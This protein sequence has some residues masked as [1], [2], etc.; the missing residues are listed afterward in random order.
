MGFNTKYHRAEWGKLLTY[1]KLFPT[2]KGVS[3]GILFVLGPGTET[4][5]RGFVS[6]CHITGHIFLQNKHLTKQSQVTLSLKECCILCFPCYVLTVLLAQTLHDCNILSKMHFLMIYYNI[7][8]IYY[9]LVRR[10]TE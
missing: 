4:L 8:E 7:N 3:F 5:Y 6:I 10:H 2:Q 1:L 9:R